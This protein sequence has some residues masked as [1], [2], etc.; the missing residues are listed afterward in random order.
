M[1]GFRV[2]GISR[3]ASGFR[4]FHAAGAFATHH[5]AILTLEGDHIAA[6]DA[7]HLSGAR[8]LGAGLA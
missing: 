4:A 6:I 1:R 7:F 5:T 2:S 3:M 8:S